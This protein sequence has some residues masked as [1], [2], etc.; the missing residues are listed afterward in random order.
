MCPA[1]SIKQCDQISGVHDLQKIQRTEV[2]AVMYSM[3]ATTVFQSWG[4]AA[5]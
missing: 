1:E 4:D 3:H 2:H 5:G